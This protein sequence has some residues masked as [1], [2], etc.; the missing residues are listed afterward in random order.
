MGA[1]PPAAVSQ[2]LDRLPGLQPRKLDA[3]YRG[4]LADDRTHHVAAADRPDADRGQP[5][6]ALSWIAGGCHGGYLRPAP[7]AH[8]LAILDAG[9]SRGIEPA[10]GIRNHL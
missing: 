2:S 7:V 6:G 5:A 3:G 1:A 4:H 9:D 8:L 10:N